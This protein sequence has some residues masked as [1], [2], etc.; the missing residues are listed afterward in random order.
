[1]DCQR[2]LPVPE[3]LARPSSSRLVVVMRY[4]EEPWLASFQRT[5][6]VAPSAGHGQLVPWT[7][8]EVAA[9]SLSRSSLELCAAESDDGHSGAG[10]EGCARRSVDPKRDT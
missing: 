3:R 5:E 2:R 9:R 4:L 8:E 10:R 7:L 1:M 6:R